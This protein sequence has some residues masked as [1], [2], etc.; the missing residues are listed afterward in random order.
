MQSDQLLS[1]DQ[2][3]LMAEK[4][5]MED[6]GQKIG[7]SHFGED[8]IVNFI[9]GPDRDKGLYV[10][11]GCYHPTLFSNTYAF[12]KTGWR[13]VL[14]DANLFM[15][16]LCREMRPE[17]ICLNL[18]VG[19]SDGKATLYKFNQWGSSNTIDPDFRD[20]I[21]SSQGVEVTESVE[22]EMR[23][24]RSLF[25]EYVGDHQIDFLNI[26][27]ENVDIDALRGNNWE[28][29]RPTVIAIEDLSFDAHDPGKSNIHVLLVN[30]GYQL[31][32][33][34]VFTSI[35][36]ASEAIDSLNPAWKQ[37]RQI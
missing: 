27:I 7:Y 22:V 1:A 9:L 34:A 28:K 36:I 17:D 11:I 16:D 6:Q 31:E 33:R 23:S 19:R 4:M 30:Q 35:Y 18:A 3:N 29:Y 32:S 21:A 14:V 24:L 5:F 12:Y 8:H 20:H 37:G 25:K 15:I 10:D 2:K 26:D 13:G